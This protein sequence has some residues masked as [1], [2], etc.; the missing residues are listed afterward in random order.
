MLRYGL[1]IPNFG[2]AAYAHT[3]AQLAVAAEK[4]GWDGFFLWDHIIEYDWRVPLVDSFTALAAIAARTKRI[5]IGTTVTPLPRLHPWTIARQTVSLDHLSNGRFTLGVGLGGEESCGYE[6]FGQDPDRRVLAGKLDEAIEIITR[7][8]K[9][10][11]VTYHGK[12][13]SV[14]NRVFLPTPVQ[15]PRVPIWVGG[16]WPTK[17]PFIRAAKWDGIIPLKRPGGLLKPND[18]RD[19]MRYMKTLRSDD[20]FD[21]AVIGW[22]ASKYHSKNAEKVRSYYDHGMTWWLETLYTKRDSPEEMAIRIRKGPPRIR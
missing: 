8:W 7:L 17:G 12:H 3:L 14:E 5:R 16:F 15:K 1:Y 10:K 22:T 11:N 19:I 2:K 13:Y 20:R 9:G 18:L 6:K 4:A 21:V